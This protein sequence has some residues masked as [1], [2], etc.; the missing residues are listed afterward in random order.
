MGEYYAVECR[1]FAGG[2]PR[3][4]RKK[5]SACM[6]TLHAFDSRSARDQW[7]ARKKKGN[8][9]VSEGGLSVT[10]SAVKACSDDKALEVVF[11]AGLESYFARAGAIVRH[12]F[13]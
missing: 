5:K 10:R 11:D 12:R 1:E 2:E 7:V 8:V 9:S 13:A 4:K 3:L 6:K